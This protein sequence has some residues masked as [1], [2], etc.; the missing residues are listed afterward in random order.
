MQKFVLIIL[1]ILATVS[2]WLLLGWLGVWGK[3]AD[4][5]I[6]HAKKIFIEEESEIEEEKRGDKDE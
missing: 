3:T 5:T 1:I 4:E 2:I 6:K